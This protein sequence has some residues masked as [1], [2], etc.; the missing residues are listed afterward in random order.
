MSNIMASK[1]N[2]VPL[3]LHSVFD[4][5]NIR[6]EKGNL[7]NSLKNTRIPHHLLQEFC[8]I[9]ESLEWELSEFAWD[10][11]GVLPFAENS[12]P[13]IITNSGRFSERAAVQL[14]RSC[15]MTPAQEQFLVMELGA[16]TGLFARL[17]LDSFKALCTQEGVDYYDRLQYVVSDRSQR[18]IDQWRERA[19]FDKHAQHVQMRVWDAITSF[20]VL[21]N[22]QLPLKAVFCNYLLDV[23]PSTVIRQGASG[24]EELMI[25]THLVSE[26]S[27][28]SQHTNLTYE[29]INHLVQ[30]EDIDQRRKLLPL[31]TLLELETAFHP[32]RSTI[33]SIASDAFACQQGVEKTVLNYGA[34]Q[35]LETCLE[36]LDESGFLLINDYGPI[37]TEDVEKQV[38]SQRFGPTLALGINFPLLES[39][40]NAGN[41]EVIIPDND[42]D[43]PIHSRLIVCDHSKV[44][45]QLF[46]DNFGSKGYIRCEAPVN[47][48]RKHA[49]AG[50]KDDALEAFNCGLANNRN[51]WYI[52]GEIAEYVGFQ[53]SDHSA[54]LEL[55][56]EAV[57]LNPW[58]SSW[59][60]N[61][62]GDCLFCL[63][64]FTDSHE[65]Y[66]QAHRIDP[67]DP[68][69][70]LNLAFCYSQFLQYDEAL[71]A[72]AKGL[73]NDKMGVYQGQLLEKQ[74][75]LLNQLSVRA[76]GEQDRL[77]RRAISQQ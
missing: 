36:A 65:A 55:V 60:W 23:L 70:N 69:T 27:V 46:K 17:F 72:I 58:Y 57:K 14:F 52:L 48:A 56:Q 31:V 64:R 26:A 76:L 66:L 67:Q 1:L 43:A 10:Q 61:I 73:A 11:Y 54:A 34:L 53:L 75:Q 28:I 47:E 5:M 63:N 74:R 25:R 2:R 51:D 45:V 44:D 39:Y 18:S 19:I 3:P 50:R 40:L 30:S 9:S 68:R 59:L 4:R 77:M 13:F 16:G 35:C 71:C 20:D 24:I 37:A 41:W 6:I 49:K 29:E 32:I 33:S 62:L 42:A 7:S 15:Q 8:P 38:A 12:V 22:R 21:E